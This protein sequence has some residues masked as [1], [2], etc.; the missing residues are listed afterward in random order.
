MTTRL[1]ALNNEKK[2]LHQLVKEREV[3]RQKRIKGQTVPDL[4]NDLKPYFSLPGSKKAIEGKEEEY[5]NGWSFK[6]RRLSTGPLE[7]SQILHYEQEETTETKVFRITKRDKERVKQKERRESFFHGSGRTSPKL[8]KISDEDDDDKKEDGKS[9]VEKLA[10]WCKK[11]QRS[12]SD[13]CTLKDKKL[14]GEILIG[15]LK[16]ILKTKGCKQMEEED[17]DAIKKEEADGGTPLIEGKDDD[18]IDYSHWISKQC[19]L[20]TRSELKNHRS[21][22]P[23]IPIHLPHGP[24]NATS[25]LS[26]TE[27]PKVREEVL[28]EKK[29]MQ[30]KKQAEEFDRTVDQL[31][32]TAFHKVK[33]KKSRKQLEDAYML[34]SNDKQRTRKAL[35]Q[36]RE[37]AKQHRLK[38]KGKKNKDVVP[39]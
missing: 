9:A 14:C 7:A 39:K 33:S 16:E 30:K 6:S 21:S 4:S 1:K 12:L 20:A 26:F 25:I 10:A 37:K 5:G 13:A 24:K 29:N 11:N 34:Y 32:H 17:E 22:V 35:E 18:K 28:K 31:E 15:E 36:A 19:M 27:L 2:K 38:E 3:E 23:N 8:D